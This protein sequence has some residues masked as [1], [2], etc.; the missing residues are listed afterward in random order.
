MKKGIC[1]LKFDC[2]LSH[3]KYF[4]STNLIGA[5]VPEKSPR[6]SCGCDRSFEILAVLK[7]YAF[8]F[9]N[10]KKLAVVANLNPYI[11]GKDIFPE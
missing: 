8:C 3:F 5:R 10:N 9:V 2:V 4:M 1:A 7:T 11:A 6:K